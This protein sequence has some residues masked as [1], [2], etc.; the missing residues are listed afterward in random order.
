VRVT[1]LFAALILIGSSA[2][3]AAPFQSART[4]TGAP[5]SSAGQVTIV[6]YW[7]TWCV[8][9]RVEMPILDAYYRRH[10]AE[11]VAMLAISVDQ[12][13]SA[14]RLQAVTSRFAFPIARVDD[15]RMPRHDI[16]TA[17]PVTRIYDRSGRLAFQFKGNGRSTID[18]VTLEQVMTPL[19]AHP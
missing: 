17:L 15:V 12:G 8:P 19:L 3:L 14:R 13:V 11:G 9:C 5:F 6:H 10:R 16:P 4:V 7:A 1:R 18:A 2:S